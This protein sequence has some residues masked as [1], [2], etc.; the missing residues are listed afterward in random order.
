M[1]ALPGGIDAHI[2]N[3]SLHGQIIQVKK[4]DNL[5]KLII[6][7]NIYRLPNE[8]VDFYNEFISEL[9]PVLKSLET[10]KIEVIVSGNFNIDLLKIINKEVFSDYFDMLTNNSFYPINTLPTRLSNKHCSLIDTLIDNIFCKLTETT[11]DTIS[12]ILIK[13]CSDHQPYFTILNN[14]NHKDHKPKYTKIV[15]QEME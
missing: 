10:N 4:G 7:D 6:I 2:W 1:G 13:K 11:L 14:I 8:L 15:K 3:L 12:G 9:S 5:T